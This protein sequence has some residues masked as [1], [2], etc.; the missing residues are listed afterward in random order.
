MGTTHSLRPRLM[1][2]RAVDL[3]RRLG[4]Q[5][6][7]SPR[8]HQRPLEVVTDLLARAHRAAVD[9]VDA[10]ERLLDLVEKQLGASSYAI[11][12]CAATANLLAL[13]VFGEPEDHAALTDLAASLGHERL[14]RMQHRYGTDLESDPRLPLTSDAMRRM[15]LPD[16]RARLAVD[17][18][19]RGRVAAVETACLRA[20][21]G[22]LVQGVDR[23]WTVPRL[24]SVEELLDMAAN[25]TIVEWRHHIAMVLEDAWSPYTTRIV[26]LA[27]QAG[28]CHTA[29]VIASII[30]LCREQAA[31]SAGNPVA[32]DLARLAQPRRN[33]ASLP[34]ATRVA[35]AAPRLR[36]VPDQRIR[37]L[38]GFA[39]P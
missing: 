37:Y 25:G 38:G 7:G 8:R 15:L 21:H 18:E 23:G 19:T 32:R 12:A 6:E 1:A 11:P 4:A 3:Q 16:L 28:R 30:D 10:W 5:L 31:S 39:A 33:R 20:A 9:D 17:P 13:A 29:S 36:V 14:A 22:L 26:E 27:Q 34:A 35:P 2:R 24:D